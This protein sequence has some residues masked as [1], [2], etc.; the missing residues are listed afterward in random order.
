MTRLT[1]TL[2][3]AAVA[4]LALAP[5]PALAQQAAR[6]QVAPQVFEIPRDDQVVLELK[7]ESW[8]ETQTALVRAS[9]DAAFGAG[10]GGDIRAQVLEALKKT[11]PEADW[12][13]TAVDQIPD[14]AGLERWR[15]TAETRLKDGALSGIRDRAQSASRSGLKVQIDQVEYTPT[16]AEREATLARLREQI[17]RDAKAELGRL[18][19]LYDDAKWRPQRIDFLPAGSVAETYAP[20]A[21]KTM[22][23][24]AP[25]MAADIGGGVMEVAQ[26]LT[27][28]AVVVLAAR[29]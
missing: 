8:V 1:S 19:G 16:V 28:R 18:N 22:T 14:P 20:R 13:L 23:M 10:Q 12:H 6:Q 2:L 21:A 25:A 15:V 5:L 26:K 29:R 3:L 24:A 27:L 11:A 17:Y 4:G 9:V 7:A